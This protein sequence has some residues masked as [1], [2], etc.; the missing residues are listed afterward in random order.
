MSIFEIS[1]F[2][3]API[4]GYY[5]NKYIYMIL[6]VIYHLTFRNLASYI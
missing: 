3:D 5:D 6:G 4:M 2:D 1:S